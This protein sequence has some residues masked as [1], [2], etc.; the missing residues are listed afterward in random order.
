[1]VMDT[2]SARAVALW[3]ALHL[4]LLL[5]LSLLVV[6]QRAKHKVMIG[7]GDAI[8]LIRASRAFGNATEY[9]PAGLAA[10]VALALVGAPALVIHAAG[11]GL[12]LGRLAH[13]Q[14][15]S[16]TENTSP[17]RA[18]GMLLTWVSF[19]FASVALLF[20]AIG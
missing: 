13:A 9:V 19:I 17:G 12:F 8:E 3:V 2:T 5:G 15:I 11:G 1:M 6:R 20:Y 16:M 4:L 10:L 18:I 14:G 7:D